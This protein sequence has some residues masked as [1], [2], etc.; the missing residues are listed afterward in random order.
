MLMPQTSAPLTPR[1]RQLITRLQLQSHP[2]GGWYREVFRSQAQVQ[3]QDTRPLRPAITSI[4]FLLEAGQYSRWHKVMSDEAWVYL[5]GAP[6]DLWSW[7]AIS[8]Q[9]CQ[10]QLGPVNTKPDGSHCSTAEPQ[11][12]INA[13]LW[14]AARPHQDAHQGFTLAACMVGPGF[15]FSDFEM[16]RPDSHEAHQIANTHSNLSHFI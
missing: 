9:V 4:Y 10:V 16:M 15:D 3:P 5:E 1:A 6:L 12:V 13:G 7:D 8:G 2:E 14:Q 11:H